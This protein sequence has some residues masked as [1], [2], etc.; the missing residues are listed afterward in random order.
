MQ[1]RIVRVVAL[2]LLAMV[3]PASASAEKSERWTIKEWRLP[4]PD[5]LPHDPAVA[6]DGALWYTAQRA[7]K[8]GRVDSAIGDSESGVKPNTIVRLDPKAENFAVLR[9]PGG[10]G[11][12]RNMAATRPGRVY[13]AESGVNTV[14]MIEPAQWVP[15]LSQIRPVSASDDGG[16]NGGM[17]RALWIVGGLLVVYIALRLIA[18][19]SQKRKPG[20]KPSA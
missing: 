4:T 10:G 14:G 6:P 11:V 19:R 18:G 7:N 16:M 1:Q 8:F 13:I 17:T 20:D 2:L 9:V 15:Q 5:S 12:I 3:I